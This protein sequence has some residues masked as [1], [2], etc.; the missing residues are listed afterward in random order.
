MKILLIGGTPGTG[1]TEVAN[2]LG[3]LL[4]REVIALGEIAERK[5]CIREHDSERDTEVIDEDCLVDAILDLIEEQTGDLI[6]E[7]HYIDLIPRNKVE[8][9]IILRT[10]PDDLKRRLL[11]RK[12]SVEKL[13]ENLE[14][15]IYGICQ[16]DA[17]DSF[18]EDL[19]YEIDTTE[20]SANLAANEI[21]ALTK[22][23]ES[24][25]R[26]DWMVELEE[27]GRL[28]EFVPDA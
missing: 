19:V 27:E 4:K 7:G 14:A 10:H 9:A 15:E 11:Q 12:Y 21:I 8:M 17:L 16:M 20:T 3:K 22:S 24:P 23:K 28:N 1:K 5:D 6:I 2:A 25:V 13:N 26:Y 18:G